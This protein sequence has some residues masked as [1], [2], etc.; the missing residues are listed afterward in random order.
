MIDALAELRRRLTER[1]EI[2]F[3]EAAGQITIEPSNEFG[4]AASLEVRQGS[5]T[6]SFDGWHEHFESGEE[7]LDCLAFGLSP[8][9]RLKIAFRGASACSWT[10]QSMHAGEWVDDSTVGRLLVPF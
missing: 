1:P 4:F 8:A 3:T 10:V 6:V 5:H 9:C 7:A 2:E